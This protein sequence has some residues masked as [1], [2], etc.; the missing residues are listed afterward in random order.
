MIQH[1]EMAAGSAIQ[2]SLPAGY[3]S[4]GMMVNVLEAVV[5]VAGLMMMLASLTTD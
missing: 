3:V 5:L 2:S 1:M 4:V